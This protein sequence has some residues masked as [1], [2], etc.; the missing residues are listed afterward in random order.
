MNRNTRTVLYGGA[1]VAALALLLFATGAKAEEEDTGGYGKLPPV[2]PPED[3]RTVPVDPGNSGAPKPRPNGDN[4]LPTA[5]KTP[6]SA[7]PNGEIDVATS[8]WPDN[9]VD[10]AR[11]MVTEEYEEGVLFVYIPQSVDQVVNSDKLVRLELIMEDWAALYGY[12]LI[13]IVYGV[14]ED[15]AYTAQV[16][17]RG[18]ERGTYDL[19][20]S[21]T[22]D[23]L[24]ALP[25]GALPDAFV[26]GLV[27]W[28]HGPS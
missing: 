16:W 2:T 6:S 21:Y 24:D 11:N 17:Y 7:P 18:N 4:I 8:S 3:P 13:H 22:T 14:P 10:N 20:I 28:L 27:E 9:P 1:T 25:K 23:Y 15:Y 5:P 12:R 19:P 26:A